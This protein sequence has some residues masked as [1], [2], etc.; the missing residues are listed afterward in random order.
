MCCSC[1]V[2]LEIRS[3]FP[4]EER[5][6]CP[7]CCQRDDVSTVSSREHQALDLPF[8]TMVA[9]LGSCLETLLITL[10]S[11]LKTKQHGGLLSEKSIYFVCKYEGVRSNNPRRRNEGW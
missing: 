10:K 7:L 1:V 6:A 4:L 8:M 11:Q 5:P 2:G 9:E 3:R